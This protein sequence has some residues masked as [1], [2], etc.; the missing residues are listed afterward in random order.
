[1]N[2]ECINKLTIATLFVIINIAEAMI[3]NSLAT[4]VFE[5]VE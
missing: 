2:D 5:I 4:L 3:L 1:M